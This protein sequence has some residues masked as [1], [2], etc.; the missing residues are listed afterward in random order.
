M[1]Q[2]VDDKKEGH[3]V[4]DGII[5]H[6][7]GTLLNEQGCSYSKFNKESL[8]DHESGL[9]NLFFRMM[10]TMKRDFW[11]VTS[12]MDHIKKTT[13]E[14][15]HTEY[16]PSKAE[17][18]EGARELWDSFVS[19]LNATDEL[20]PTSK[21]LSVFQSITSKDETTTNLPHIKNKKPTQMPSS[22]R[23]SNYHHSEATWKELL[24]G[25]TGSWAAAKYTHDA[26]KA[27]MYK[28]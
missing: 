20:N 8:Q 2:P 17:G 18:S 16:N 1:M 22:P 4:I 9:K 25:Q 23:P 21:R 14:R 3:A 19:N 5:E 12:S 26:K 11:P 7:I 27:Q 10:D 6:R 28:A 13:E 15:N 24:E